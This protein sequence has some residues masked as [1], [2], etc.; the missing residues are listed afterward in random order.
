MDFVKKGDLKLK[1]K[2][3]SYFQSKILLRWEQ[4]GAKG[5]VNHI[6]LDTLAYFSKDFSDLVKQLASNCL[7][8]ILLKTT[9]VELN[10]E[11]TPFLS[12][13]AISPCL[14]VLL[15]GGFALLFII[16]FKKI[17]FLNDVTYNK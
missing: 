1:K 9:Q 12:K 3:D 14:L 5:V 2:N 13:N 6:S 7:Q 11:F 16:G 10:I 4:I 8:V 17:S 15:W